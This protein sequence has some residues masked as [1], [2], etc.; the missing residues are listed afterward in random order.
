VPRAS[1][2]RLAMEA[3]ITVGEAT[4]VWL[5]GYR[6]GLMPSARAGERARKA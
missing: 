4:L 3:K 6:D 2:D 5:R 1:F